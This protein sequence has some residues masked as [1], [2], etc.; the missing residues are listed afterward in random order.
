[1]NGIHALDTS[2]S[3]VVAEEGRVGASVDLWAN[4]KADTASRIRR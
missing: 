4:I 3:V 1:M 2:A